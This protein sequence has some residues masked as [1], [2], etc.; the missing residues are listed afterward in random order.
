MPETMQLEVVTPSRKVLEAAVESVTLPGSEGE[1]GILPEHIPLV[2]TLDTGVLSYS[3]KGETRALAVHWGYAQV[4]ADRVSVLAE[5]V[6]SAHEID[7]DRAQQA[8]TRV[9]RQLGSRTAAT[10]EVRGQVQAGARA[11]AGFAIWLTLASPL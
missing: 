11:P 7:V 8:E 3:S 6:E 2:T 10:L 1:L 5:L 4:E 9:R